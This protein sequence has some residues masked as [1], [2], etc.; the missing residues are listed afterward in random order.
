MPKSAFPPRVFG[1]GGQSIRSTQH[2]MGVIGFGFQIAG[3]SI[4]YHYVGENMWLLK[5]RSKG[6]RRSSL[7]L[8]LRHPRSRRIRPTLGEVRTCILHYEYRHAV[9]IHITFT[10]I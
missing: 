10:C 1:S 6:P 2:C 3:H 4:R 5:S 7:P 9:H 8:S